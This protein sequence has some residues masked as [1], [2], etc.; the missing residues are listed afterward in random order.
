VQKTLIAFDVDRIK[1]YVFATDK[2]NEIR[3]ASALLDRLNRESMR[4]V[5]AEQ[6]SSTHI[7]TIYTNGGQ[8]LFLVMGDDATTHTFGKAVKKAFAATTYDGAS[9]TYVT[10]PLP[11]DLPDDA[12]L[13]R[14]TDLSKYFELIQ[15]KIQLKKAS[16]PATQTLISHP[17]MQVCAACG[18]RYAEKQDQSVLS[19]T[20]IRLCCSSCSEKQEEDNRIKKNLQDDD[21]FTPLHK[22]EVLSQKLWERIIFYLQEDESTI[23]YPAYNFFP[24][25]SDK[26]AKPKRPNDFNV[27][28]QFRQQKEYIGLIYADANN[29]GKHVTA[30]KTL[31]DYKNF[32]EEVDG[33]IHTALARAIKKHLPVKTIKASEEENSGPHFPFDIFMVGGDDI[34]MLTSAEQAMDVANTIAQEFRKVANNEY[35]LSIGIVLAPIKYPFGQLLG[36]VEQELKNAKKASATV[37]QRQAGGKQ[38]IAEDDSRLSFTVVTGGMQVNAESPYYRKRKGAGKEGDLEFF[39]TLRPYAPAQ[40]Q[41]LL[42]TI[43]EG[44]KLNLG[45]TKLHQLREAI[46]KMNHTTSLI[47][48]MAVLHNWKP[49]QREF[50]INYLCKCS[51]D[52][53]YNDLQQR[54]T[55]SDGK[56]LSSIYFPWFMTKQDQHTIYRTSLLDLVELYDFVAN[57]ESDTGN[58]LK[59]GEQ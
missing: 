38:G 33:F 23:G 57:E 29:M 4:T 44:E 20:E 28:R 37:R 48:G 9:V 35:S 3:G 15:V 25:E 8:G 1:D 22:S 18:L 7:I 19:A 17:L 43:R 53:A 39:A 56:Y 13:I 50:I 49:Q 41:K 14:Q 36:L 51:L 58:N 16:P 6:F 42:Q 47:D 5:A 32:A 46:I 2:L 12:N 59:K 27:F 34:I 21:V 10:Q 26:Q 55:A 30:Q 31:N 11:D 52:G 45:R 24:D 40:L 54:A